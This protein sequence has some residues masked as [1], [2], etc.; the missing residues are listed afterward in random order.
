MTLYFDP[1]GLHIT[2]MFEARGVTDLLPGL[3]PDALSEGDEWE[4]EL[5]AEF[6]HLGE[7]E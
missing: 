7:E 2:E 6:P 1:H 5:V 4:D 3:L